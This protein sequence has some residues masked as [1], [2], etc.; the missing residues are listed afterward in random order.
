MWVV[1]MYQM[2]LYKPSER[3]AARAAERQVVG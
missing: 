2:W 3:F 1:S